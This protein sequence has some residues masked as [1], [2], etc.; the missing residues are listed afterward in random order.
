MEVKVDQK[1]IGFVDSANPLHLKT[2]AQ[3]NKKYL[4]LIGPEGDFS[5]EELELAIQNGFE[6]VSLGTNR[7][8]TET[9]GLLAVQVLA[10]A[11]A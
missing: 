9:A 3:P 11:N 1:F 10:L 7:L 2:L 5:K 8:R 6:K 4:M